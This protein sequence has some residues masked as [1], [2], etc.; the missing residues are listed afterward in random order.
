MFIILIGA[1]GSGKG[2]QGRFLSERL[3]CPHVS[4]G[5]IFREM[6]N[7]TTLEG[8][9]ISA[10]TTKGILVPSDLVNG[11][12]S[13]FLSIRAYLEHCILDGYP[14]NI[15]QA[16]FF[17][18][19]VRKVCV[20]YLKISEQ[21]ALQRV[22]GRF[23]CAVCGQIYNKTDTMPHIE[24]VCDVCSSSSFVYRGDD[25]VD[26]IHTRM[27]EYTRETQPVVEYYGRDGVLLTVDAEKKQEEVSSILLDLLK[28]V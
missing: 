17:S 11:V 7:S 4:T 25:E 8:E 1:P 22:L 6:A 2:T 23:S 16:E 18:T 12:V 26:V 24:D 28:R 21:V 27:K 19:V 14:R 5:D 20:V 10:Y 9:L 3:C 13:S 15:S